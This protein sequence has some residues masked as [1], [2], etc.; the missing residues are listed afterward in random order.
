M[1]SWARLCH[2]ESVE[3]LIRKNYKIKLCFNSSTSTPRVLSTGVHYNKH[4]KF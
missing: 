1:S 4:I 3:G 2:P